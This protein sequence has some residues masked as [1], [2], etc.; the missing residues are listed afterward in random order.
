[1]I[2]AA[3]FPLSELAEECA[4]SF[5]EPAEL[6]KLRLRTEIQP[7]LT[8]CG[9]RAQIGQLL[10]ILL[11]NAI[12][13]TPEGGDIELSLKQE[14]RRILRVKNT[15]NDTSVSPER[16]FDRFYRTDESRTQKSGGFG[17]GLSAARAIAEQHHGTLTAGYEGDSIVFTLS[18]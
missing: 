3:D 10:S 18:L 9:N 16:F 13:Y 8:L 1:M 17:I 7:G 6:K 11:D 4:R 2:N 15:V 5:R 14:G 12:K